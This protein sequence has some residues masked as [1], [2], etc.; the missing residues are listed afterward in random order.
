MDVNHNSLEFFQVSRKEEIGYA[1][2]A[3]F[4]E[5]SWVGFKEEMIALANGQTRFEREIPIR[6]WNGEIKQLIIVL[7]VAP[8]YQDTLDRVL[9]SFIDITARKH[10]EEMLKQNEIWLSAIFNNSRDAIGVSKDGIQI[11]VNPA[12][13]HM[14][15]YEHPTDL[16]GAPILNI[17][18]PESRPVVYQHIQ[19]R[20]RGE[21]APLFYEV[22]ALRLDG[23]TFP[24][25][26]GVSTYDL[27]GENYTLVVL[28]DTTTRTQAEEAIRASEEKF[29]RAFQHAPLLVTLSVLETGKFIDVN[30]EFLR[31]SG[32]SREEVIGAT[33]VELGWV[34]LQDRSQIVETVRSQKRVVGVELT[35]YAKD[36]HPVICL[37]NGDLIMLGGQECLFSI[38]QDITERKRVEEALRE[39]EKLYRTL[40]EMADDVIILTDLQ[41]NHLFRNNAYYT[42]LGFAVGEGVELDGFA[43][44]HPDDLP[45]VRTGMPNLFMKGKS[46]GEYR[47]QHRDGHW[48][49]RYNKA[50]IISDSEGHPQAI[51]SIIRDITERKQTEERLAH[52]EKLFRALV[53]NSYEAITLVGRDGRAKYQSPSVTKLTGFTTEEALHHSALDNV[54]PGDLAGLQAIYAR[55]L[56][57]PG[58]IERLEFRSVRKDG[59]LWWTEATATNLLDDP[60]LEAI[61]VNFRDITERK[62]AEEAIQRSLKEKEALMHELQHRV[63]NSLMVASGLLSLEE[64]SLPDDRTRAVFANTRSRLH[65]MSA[66]YEQLYRSGGIDCVDL[67]Q[68][69][70]N[71]VGG[72]VQS[73]LPQTG[74]VNI[75]THLEAVQLDL[76]RTLPLGIILN[77]LVTNALKH[78]FVAGK[79]PSGGPG[80]IRVELSQ[81]AGQVKMCVMDNGVGMP[82]TD[83][84]HEGIGLELVQML[85]AQMDGSF[86]FEC[87]QGCVAYIT[88]SL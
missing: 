17:I 62:Q 27:F 13:A 82:C 31:V 10:A 44:I 9:V 16:I 14:F 29:S 84:R 23:T 77:E 65:S 70:E 6:F 58:S 49:Y 87:S 53:E 38:A 41:G 34:R 32:F 30:D 40:V 1:L 75:E 47:V 72:L 28:R 18:A 54:Y 7:S 20:T 35:L 81:T 39:N 22:T 80:V 26:V 3:Y 74:S 69:I 76:K 24:M 37:Y 55:V 86:T 19:K 48:V 8:S 61:V 33:P 42:S 85:I 64:D 83:Q 71:L 60:D 46:T 21:Q 66:V 4:T 12:Y 51:L 68:Y 56:S 50:S 5:D 2:P 79:T 36:K 57:R 78:A 67:H 25:E 52:N 88:F 15:G 45:A 73:Y 43:R 59:T 63:K 11:L